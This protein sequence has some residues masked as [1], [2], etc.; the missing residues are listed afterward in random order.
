MSSKENRPVVAG[1]IGVKD[2]EELRAMHSQWVEAELG[3][4]VRL[5]R[6][7]MGTEYSCRR[8]GFCQG[9]PS[10]ARRKGDRTWELPDENDK[11]AIKNI[12]QEVEEFVREQDGTNGQVK[13]ARKKL[14]ESGYHITK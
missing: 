13:A 8:R 4:V 7:E 10:R 14:T 12:T 2:D 3:A 11:P 9:N 6:C 1:M 5:S